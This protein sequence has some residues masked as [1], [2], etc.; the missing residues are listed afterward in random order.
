MQPISLF[1]LPTIQ[2][3]QSERGDLI[4]WF[5]EEINRE[6][7]GTKFKPLTARAVA[8]KTSHLSLHDLYFM[9]SQAKNYKRRN[10]SIS[11]Y[12]FGSL[13]VDNSIDNKSIGAK[14]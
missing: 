3:S 4:S 7:K 14:V 10:G 11:R 8:I 6:R 5:Q 2:K 12:F 13:K 1:S 9:Q